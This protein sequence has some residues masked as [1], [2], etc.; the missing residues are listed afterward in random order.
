MDMWEQSVDSDN[1]NGVDKRPAKKPNPDLG[2]RAS[3]SLNGHGCD[4]R[5]N[6]V[7]TQRGHE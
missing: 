7:P 2:D 6:H 5:R 1:G 4:D 3:N